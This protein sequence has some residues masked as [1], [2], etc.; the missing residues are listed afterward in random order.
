LHFV[1]PG[2]QLRRGCDARLYQTLAAAS[3]WAARYPAFDF[4]PRSICALEIMI[5]VRSYVFPPAIGHALQKIR[6]AARTQLLED[7]LR[8]LENLEHVIAIN[9]LCV[10]FERADALAQIGPNGL[11]DVKRTFRRIQI[12]FT[13]KKN[14][15]LLYCCVIGALVERTFVHRALTEKRNRY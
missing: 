15:Q 3:N 8:G 13:H 4:F 6:T 1:L 11:A 5:E 10:D 9:A 12:V 14:G 2:I 7:S